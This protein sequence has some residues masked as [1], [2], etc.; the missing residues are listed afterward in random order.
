[1]NL[2]PFWI[3]DSEG[4]Q[5]VADVVHGTV[6]SSEEIP[7]YLA[8]AAIIEQGAGSGGA[9][10]EL[11]GSRCAVVATGPC[12]SV[13]AVLVDIQTRIADGQATPVLA[14]HLD[15]LGLR[16]AVEAWARGA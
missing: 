14:S 16:D 10:L 2:S 11:S 13:S 9:V 15:A 12:A 1:M 8:T 4:H 5:M 3:D 6:E 7:G